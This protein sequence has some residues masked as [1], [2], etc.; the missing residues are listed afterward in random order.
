MHSYIY[1]SFLNQK[2]YDRVLA[3][4]ETRL[5]DLGL[6]GKICRLSIMKN[7]KEAV[8]DELDHGTKTIV[9]VG[10]NLTVNRIVNAL[11][12]FDVPIGIIPIEEE[13]NSIAKSLGILNELQACE[14]LSARRI[15]KIDLILANNHYIISNTR[16]PNQGT[17]L[18]IS[19]NY[20]IEIN[21]PG[22]VKIINLPPL[23]YVSAIEEKI[24]PQDGVFELVIEAGRRKKL[25]DQPQK[26]QS[27]FLLKKAV[28][29]NK[30]CPVLLDDCLELN[31]P[32]T[33]G[34]V[35]QKLKVI[36]GKT[37]KF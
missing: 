13:K 6:N 36:V 11:P 5:T 2:K 24:N 28:I 35:K 37:R 1:D 29:N 8:A 30:K 9:A 22:Q 20:T 17:I 7:V 14:I 26:N 31:A 12:A 3:Q 4:I 25:F 34:I 18:E 16:I 32:V 23:K 15:T 21:D 27:V 33:F 10:N 19:K